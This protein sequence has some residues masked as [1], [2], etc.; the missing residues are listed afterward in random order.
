[1]G[2]I[3]KVVNGKSLMYCYLGL[4]AGD[5][6]S[7]L[8]SQLLKSRRKVVLMYLVLTLCLTVYFLYFAHGITASAYYWLCFFI[9]CSAGYWALFVTIASE[10]FGTNI[11]ST[12]TNTVPN[13]VRGSVPVIMS[14]FLALSPSF[15]NIQSAM[16]IGG[17]VLVL[18]LISILYLK[19][20][21]S[22]DLDYTE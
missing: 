18:S 3:G 13:F 2:V 1:M 19:E 8:L 7:G 12:V 6:L 9:G 17:I 14:S 21:F 10:Q 20:S 16:L 15:G 4:S 5:V 11:R 22:K